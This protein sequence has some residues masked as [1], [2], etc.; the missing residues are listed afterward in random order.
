M[1]VVK[2][3]IATLQ[4][5]QNNSENQQVLLRKKNRLIAIIIAIGFIWISVLGTVLYLMG[6]EFWP[7]T[8]AAVMASALILIPFYLKVKRIDRS[9]RNS[10][11]ENQNPHLL[12]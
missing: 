1:Q 7:K 10:K 6:N 4:E 3:P 2:K 9:I 8:V 12:P 11:P 5:Q